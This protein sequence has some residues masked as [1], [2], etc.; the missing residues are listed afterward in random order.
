MKDDDFLTQFRETPRPAFAAQLYR[1]I[2]KPMNTTFS[3]RPSPARR[4][5]LAG[6][7]AVLLLVT[8]LALSPAARA[9]AGEL[10]RQVGAISVVPGETSP[11]APTAVPPRPGDASFAPTAA[12]ATALAGFPVLETSWLPAGYQASG[13]WAVA[14]QGQGVI[15]A[16]AYVAGE[17]DDFL[18]LNQYRYGS[19]DQFEQTYGANETMAEIEVRGRQG[20]AISGRLVTHPDKPEQ[21]PQPTN[22]LMWEENGVTYTLFANA[23][24]A[25]ELAQIA[26]G[27]QQ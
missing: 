21:A 14:P 3:K 9:V 11:P 13:D 5:A 17:G 4:L 15:V 10:M 23:L 20:L 1:R 24:S 18:M 25:A 16:R 12:G 6:S 19:E 27:L 22:W 26:E 2:N 7:M 8:L